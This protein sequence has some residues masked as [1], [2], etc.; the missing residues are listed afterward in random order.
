MESQSRL[1]EVKGKEIRRVVSLPP[2]RGE[3]KAKIL[4]HIIKEVKISTSMKT[5]KSLSSCC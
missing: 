4:G 3:I 2:R 1:V 5:P